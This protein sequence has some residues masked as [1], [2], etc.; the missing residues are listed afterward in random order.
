V[1]QL[2]IEATVVIDRPPEV[3]FKFTAQDHLANHPRWDPAVGGVEALSEGV[4][5]LG[6][7]FRISR[8]TGGRDEARTFEVVEWNAPARFAIET[9]AP[10]FRL[11]LAEDLRPAAPGQTLMALVG[12]AEIGGIRGL[13][14]PLVRERQE[15][16]L[17]ENLVRIKRMV[18]AGD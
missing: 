17:R 8:R 15:R 3:V 5:R 7:R 6:S 14:A 11:R 10:G 18:E 12:E 13:L 16:G 2:R 1:S 4:L 9:R